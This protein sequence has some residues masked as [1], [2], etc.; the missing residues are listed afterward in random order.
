MQGPTVFYFISTIQW[1]TKNKST[2]PTD[3]NG[4]W[5]KVHTSCFSTSIGKKIGFGNSSKFP[6]FLTR[7]YIFFLVPHE[8]SKTEEN[9]MLNSAIKFSLWNF[10]A[11]LSRNLS[12][13]QPR[14]RPA[15]VWPAPKC[16]I[17]FQKTSCPCTGTTWGDRNQQIWGK[18]YF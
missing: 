2:L 5:W 13:K 11:N 6:R 3:K 18:L 17:I 1:V 14:Q 15:L 4:T 16:V 9:A 12:G 7:N 8:E 10:V